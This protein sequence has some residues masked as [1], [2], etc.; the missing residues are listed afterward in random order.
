MHTDRGVMYTDRGINRIHILYFIY[1]W[2]TD[3]IGTSY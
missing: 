3:N 2:P 1:Q